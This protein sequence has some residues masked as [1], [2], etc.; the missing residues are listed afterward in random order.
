MKFLSCKK[1]LC[2]SPHPDDV[3][4]AISGTIKKCDQTKF[5][6][7]C[8]SAS[9]K[10][11]KT[12]TQNRYSEIVKFWSMFKC[13]NL[14]QSCS[15]DCYIQDKPFEE[16]VQLIENTIDD[17]GFDC[18]LVP[19][20]E[21]S[22]NDHKYINSMIEPILRV[23]NANFIE[24]KTPSSLN[25]WIPNLFVDVTEHIDSKVECLYN[26]FISQ[27]N[28]SYFEKENLKNFHINFQCLKKGVKY[29]EQFRIVRYN[30]L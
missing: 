18:V 20:F 15:V 21:D 27:N 2:L 25:S 28:K 12:V 29:V 23:N 24:Y 26:S 13:K 3:E 30:L 9:G 22:H 8:F 14:K 4:Y 1:V 6:S 7:F 19:S 5:E 16:W 10:N 11:D 17:D